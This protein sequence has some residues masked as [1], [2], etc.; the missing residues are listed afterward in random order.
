MG[1]KLSAFAVAAVCLMFLV[2]FSACTGSPTG[3]LIKSSP[4]EEEAVHYDKFISPLELQNI[5]NSKGVKIIDV[6]E[7]W[8]Y[9]AGHIP[10]AISIPSAEINSIR[11]NAEGI[12]KRFRII[13]Y[14]DSGTF[15]LSA[16]E[17][18][19]RAGFSKTQVLEGG[20]NS[21]VKNE[22]LIEQSY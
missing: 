8:R 22:L 4:K 13:I 17:I 5:V 15:S 20:Y 11:L 14:D 12:D 19:S 2:L 18:L 21:W 3:Q 10:N 7:A 9:N 16:F 6:R 1:L